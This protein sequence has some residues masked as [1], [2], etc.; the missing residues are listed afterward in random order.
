M[1]RR[2]S[3]VVCQQFPRSPLKP[4]GKSKFKLLAEHS[5]EGVT[6]DDPGHMTKMAAMAINS[7]KKS[8]LPR[9][10]CPMILKLGMK[11]QTIEFFKADIRHVAGVTLT[12]FTAMSN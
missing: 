1:P 2:P 3:D 6:K 10:I 9:T 12:Y 5:Q 7:K 11:H 4:N 8:I